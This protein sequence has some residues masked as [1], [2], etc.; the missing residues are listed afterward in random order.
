MY[1]HHFLNART[2]FTFR[3]KGWGWGLSTFKPAKQYKPKKCFKP[4]QR[5]KTLQFHV[6]FPN[7]ILLIY[8]NFVIQ[9]YFFTFCEV[10]LILLYLLKTHIIKIITLNEFMLLHPD[11]FVSLNEWVNKIKVADWNKPEEIRNT[12]ATADLLGNNS[13]RVIFNICGNK[14]RLIVKYYFGKKEIHL[15]I[16]WI[17]THADYTKLCKENK[18]YYIHIY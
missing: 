5:F 2:L 17:G 13:S 4:K 14:Y 16:C 3:G 10:S 11:S 18:Q 12:F 6:V 15:F 8:S 9:F 1:A 7:V